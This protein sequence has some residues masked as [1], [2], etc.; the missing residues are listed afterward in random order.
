MQGNARVIN[1]TG[2]VRGATQRLVK[3]EMNGYSNDELIGYLD[4]I[5]LELS[6]GEGENG[7]IVLPDAE[8]QRLIQD[9]GQAWEEIKNEIV[10][11]RQS[12]YKQ[13]LFELSETYFDM[14][15]MA[16]SAAERY[17]EENVDNAKSVLICLNV[18]F[19]MISFL[20]WIYQ[21]RQRKVQLALDMAE[22]ASRAKSEFLSRMSHEIRTPMNGIIGMTAIAQMS[23]DNRDKLVNCLKKIELSSGYLL[24]LIN[25][26]LDMSRIE[27]GKLEIS[28][29]VFSLRM[30]VENLTGLYYTQAFNKGIKYETVLMG[31]VPSEIYGDS[32]RLNQVLA[33]LLSNAVKFTPTGGMVRLRISQ[34]VGIDGVSTLKFEVSDTGCG[35]EEDRF[36][37]IFEAFEQE[38]GAVAHVYG[39]T[40]LGLSIVKRLVELMGGSVSLQSKP[41][42]GSTFS[43]EIPLEGRE[44]SDERQVR[45]EGLKAI[46]VGGD[47]EVRGYIHNQLIYMGMDAYV[48]EDGRQALDMIERAHQDG[49]DF[50]FCFVN[51]KNSDMDGM[52]VTRRIRKMDGGELLKVLILAYDTSDLEN[53]SRDAGADGVLT[54]P[55]FK[56]TIEEAVDR[57]ESQGSLSQDRADYNVSYDFRGKRFLLAEDNEI[58]REIA[59]ELLEAAGAVMEVAE[60]GIQAVE[61]FSDSPEGY[62]DLILMDIQMPRMNGYEATRRIRAMQRADSKEIPIFAMTADAFSEDVEKSR[63]AGMNAHISKPLDVGLIYERIDAVIRR[64]V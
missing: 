40:G 28:P 32:L 42:E 56:S 2:I 45:Y 37:K 18:G 11:V 16:V 50:D 9:M 15:N 38:N 7:L 35:I 20:F 48:A 8:Y 57:I 25:D 3:Q 60:D 64:D 62:Y 58:N 63:T 55:L 53:A 19:V 47:S 5:I 33:N 61:R 30:L 17:S 34:H 43:V 10:Q 51:W 29:E 52:E 46:V 59:V 44:S 23:L 26:I 41:G 4:G 21:R 31:E 39:G 14:A 24:A 12:E 13:R 6:T 49:A 54:K 22:S 27:S 1:Y 36:D